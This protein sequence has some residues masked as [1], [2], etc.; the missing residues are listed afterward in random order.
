VRK[1]EAEKL[2]S[3]VEPLRYQR[4]LLENLRLLEVIEQELSPARLEL[5]ALMGM[6]PG[7]AATA[8]RVAE[9]AQGTSSTWLQRPVEDMEA[10]A[11]VRNPD[12]RESQY[13]ARIAREETK[14][15]MLRMFPGL[16]F[17]YAA[18]HST[19]AI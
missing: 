19:T 12:L 18:N 9:P 15:V 2:R 17:N 11:L 5:A 16:S 13:G 7:Q 8:W 4:Q 10:L 14:R 6:A 1:V 3:P